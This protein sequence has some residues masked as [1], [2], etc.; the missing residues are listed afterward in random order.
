[1]GS[2]DKKCCKPLKKYVV[3]STAQRWTHR[4]VRLIDAEQEDELG[5]EERCYQVP[6]DGVEVGAE[7]AQEAQQ[8]EGEEEEEQGDRHCGVGDDL[9]GENVAV[10]WR[11]QDVKS[12]S[13]QKAEKQRAYWDVFI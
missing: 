2:F 4:V 11:H 3:V 1:M 10:L 8:D 9:Q 12:I 5:E 7:A 6:V 13:R